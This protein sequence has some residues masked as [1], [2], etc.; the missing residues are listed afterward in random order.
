MDVRLPK[1]HMEL[2]RFKA[3]K[4]VFI[5][6]GN[7][8]DVHAYPTATE[9][10]YRWDLLKLDQY[11]YRYLLCNGY[12]TVIF[13]NHVDGFYNEFNTQHLK[14]FLRFSSGKEIVEASEER[15]SPPA[16]LEKHSA[17]LDR[18]TEMI[19]VALDNRQ[20]PLAVVMNM[21]SRY[22]ATPDNL[23]DEE[24]QFYSRLL[25]TTMK[26][27]QVRVESTG[28]FVNNLLFLIANKANDIPAW[29]YLENP[30]VKTIN[31]TKPDKATRR[32]FIDTH[33]RFFLN[34]DQLSPEELEKAKEK[35]VD[36][37]DGFKNLE[38]NGLRMLCQQEN[39]PVNRLP[40]AIALYKYGIKEN[41]WDEI[42]GDKLNQAED[43]I[44]A[45]VKGQPAAI[46]QTLDII[47]RAVGGMSGLQHSSSSS[48]PKGILFFAGPTGTGKTELAKTLANLL[49]GDDNACIRFDMSEY[50]QP[51]S[52]QKLLGAPPGYVGYEAGGQ[53]TNAVKEKPF[54]ILLFDE[55]EKAHGSILDKFLQ[56]L[57]DGRMTD[58]QGETVYFSESIIIF[59]SNLGMFTR[60]EYGNR[61]P[62]VTP[63]MTYK[64]MR[65][66]ILRG[67]KD[68][69]ILELGRPEI[70]NRIGNNFVVFDYIREDVARE[71]L[72]SQLKKIID[73][74]MEHKGIEVRLTEAT[75]EQLMDIIR[76]SLENGGRGIGNTVEK[77]FINPLSRYLFDEKINGNCV[78]SIEGISEENDIVRLHCSGGTG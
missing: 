62:N 67:I 46:T 44:K 13:Y 7:I 15:E 59:T 77:Y 11:L 69:F 47:K 78:I 19:R 23:V 32:R 5:V 30:Y 72:E 35:F 60:D 51:H 28:Q 76:G 71:I 22:I 70:L 56:I 25:L 74:L 21:A 14:N 26:P 18:A 50:Q 8:Y 2:D 38:L 27:R 64:E 63:D 52:D 68:Y 49:F 16:R 10:G 45:R 20:A 39:I 31:V 12:Q 33:V 75:V 55:I 58:G 24:R 1:W 34:A 61:Q 37:T 29:F 43:L 66:R 54:S 57:E 3:F 4:T 40:D 17:T 48:K 65:E 53:L 42:G 9:E 36:L 73:N 6:E 41:P